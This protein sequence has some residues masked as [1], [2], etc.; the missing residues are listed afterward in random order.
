MKIDDDDDDDDDDDNDNSPIPPI[1]IFLGMGSPGVSAFFPQKLEVF[2]PAEAWRFPLIPV[3]F[4]LSSLGVG[5]R[6]GHSHG[7]IDEP[8]DF[9]GYLIC[10]TDAI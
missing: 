1:P 10:S 9:G 6:V 8:T 7:A 5:V 4:V 2:V 3:E